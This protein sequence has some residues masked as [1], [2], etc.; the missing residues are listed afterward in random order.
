MAFPSPVRSLLGVRRLGVLRRADIGLLLGLLLFAAVWLVELNW[1][2]L[3]PPFDNIEQIT[4][5]G[6]LEWGY[7]KHPPLPTWLFWL[8]AHALGATAWATYLCGA[9][10]TL[11]AAV[12]MWRLLVELRGPR[13]A[14][15]ALLGALCITYYNGRLYYY[16]HNIVLL[17]FV[18]A[19]AY[20][21]WRAVMTGARRWWVALGVAVGLGFLSKYQMAVTACSFFAFWWQQGGWR[22]A[23]QRRG[24]ALAGAVTVAIFLPH[25]VWLVTHDFEPVHYAMSSSL[26]VGLSIQAR[27]VDSLRWLVDQWLNRALPSWLLL[28]VGAL[29]VR[30]A[31]GPAGTDASPRDAARALLLAW[32]LVPVVFMP[33]VGLLFGADLQLQW[34]TPFLMFLVPAVME[35]LAGVVDWARVPR[36]AMVRDFIAIQALLLAINIVTSPW[37]P[38]AARDN[39][40]REFDSAQL[41]RSIEGPAQRKIGG[42][43]CVVSGPAI[44]AGALA[45]A[46]HDHPK[47]LIDGRYDISPWVSPQLAQRCGVLE[48][49]DKPGLPGAR[50]V[51]PR[52]PR[53]FWRVVRGE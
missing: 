19:S 41:A 31:A 46:M 29:A 33:A 26:G 34:G 40:W 20:A 39:H 25:G 45:L 53:L 32:G 3:A 12:L 48:L 11:G 6:A 51:G 22:H 18:S 52:F 23:D 49:A 43:V 2:S 17:F 42:R 37:G 4:W 21:G 24:V 7:Y 16:N 27:L 30:R 1:T 36:A 28:G 15:I 10:F 38:H 13:H 47:V 50:P 44:V 9:A 14:S 35:L 5:V 8:P